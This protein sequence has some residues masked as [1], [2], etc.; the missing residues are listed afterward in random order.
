MFSLLLV[1][2]TPPPTLLVSVEELGS[3]VQAGEGPN[4]SVSLGQFCLV[5]SSP[6]S[7]FTSLPPHKAP[8]SSCSPQQPFYHQWF[9]KP[10]GGVFSLPVLAK[11]TMSPALQYCHGR[12][13]HNRI[14]T[15]KVNYYLII[16]FCDMR[17]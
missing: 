12:R 7:N 6:L 11:G 8:K 10:L 3:A 15:N 1:K 13:D 9:A 14:I 2:S 16:E 4:N 17:I 5:F